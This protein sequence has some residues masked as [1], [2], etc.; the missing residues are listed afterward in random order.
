MDA[1][2]FETNLAKAIQA[3]DTKRS[4]LVAS[5]YKRGGNTA[6][7]GLLDKYDTLRSHYF[8]LLDTQLDASNTQLNQLV[9]LAGTDAASL[10]QAVAS[11]SNFNNSIGLLN[12]TLVVL[13]EIMTFV[14]I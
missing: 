4:L 10:N 8:D 3:F 6:V 9:Q 2:T 11:M 12:K 7:N 13:G 5:A 14:G 1:T